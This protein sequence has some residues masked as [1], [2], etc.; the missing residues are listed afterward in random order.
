MI[1]FENLSNEAA[2]QLRFIIYCGIDKELDRALE[3]NSTLILDINIL[4]EIITWYNKNILL[5]GK[6]LSEKLELLK[7]RN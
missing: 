5:S 4:E 3:N 6:S 2:Y 1:K 7:A